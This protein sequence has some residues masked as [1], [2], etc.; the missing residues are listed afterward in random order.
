MRTGGWSL[1]VALAVAVHV[2]AVAQTAVGDSLWR[3]GKLDEA[4]QAYE[5]AIA[6]DRNAVRA[7]FRLAQAQAWSSNIDSALVLLRAARERVPDDPDLR[8]AEAT[9]L[10]WARRWPESLVRYDSLSAAHPGPDFEYVRIARARTLSWAGRLSDARAGYL[11]VLARVPDDRD[12]RF[13]LAQVQAWSGDLTGAA[14]GYSALLADD[15]E[16][17]RVLLALA[18][19][20]NWQ[21][22]PGTARRLLDRAAA[23][24]PDD[25]DA[26]ALRDALRV[27]TAPRLAVLQHYS[28]D[29]DR[30]VNRWTMATLRGTFDDLRAS[31]TWGGLQATDPLRDSRRQ[32]VEGSVSMPT[33]PATVTAGVGVRQLSPA[34]RDPGTVPTPRDRGILTWRLAA[35]LPVAPALS[36]TVAVARW[37]FDEI[38][39]LLG[40]GLDVDQQDLSLGWRPLSK[41]TVTATATRLAFSD[42]N[43][44]VG[45]SLRAAYRLPFGF[46]AGVYGLGFGFASRAAGYFSPSAFRAAEVTTSWNRETPRWTAG[47]SGGIGRQVVDRG[48]PSQLQWH[49]DAR[50]SRQLVPGLSV[51]VFGAS[52]TSAAASAVG[53]YRYDFMGL[54]L[55]WRPR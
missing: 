5:R 18:S 31:L 12:A 45:G 25:A 35:Q 48:L 28:E 4:R 36:A 19:V 53:A 34:W 10:A 8:F 43:E 9:Y 38:A 33:G 51:E 54:G 14:D 15:P 3:L 49:L 32:M 50:V 40:R 44:R 41:L 30:N 39:S 52:S 29:S 37:P 11:D 24:A 2:P 22:R 27:A 16:D 26:A 7:N 47:L 17:P 6:E 46:T 23:R 21:G 1:L 13:G 55:Q 42:A 20:R